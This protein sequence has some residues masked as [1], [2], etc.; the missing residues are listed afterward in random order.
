MDTMTGGI[1]NDSRIIQRIIWP[2][3]EAIELDGPLSQ[4]DGRLVTAISAYGEPGPYCMLPW[5]AIYV[6]A[7]I[8]ARIPASAVEIYYRPHESSE[9]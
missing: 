1:L 5:L 2:N 6:G 7:Q 3:E 9:D 4:W 8:A